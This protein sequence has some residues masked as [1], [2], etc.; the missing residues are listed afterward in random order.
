MPLAS[1]AFCITLHEKAMNVNGK[2][3]W[4]SQHQYIPLCGHT[5]WSEE[6]YRACEKTID[7]SPH[8]DIMHPSAEQQSLEGRPGQ[9]CCTPS[10]DA[11]SLGVTAPA[12]VAHWTVQHSEAK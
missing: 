5:L 3:A 6:K 12:S 2:N 8:D 9:A 1:Q 10:G 11:Q 7:L 4:T